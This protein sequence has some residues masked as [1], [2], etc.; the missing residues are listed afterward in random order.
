LSPVYQSTARAPCKLA[1]SETTVVAKIWVKTRALRFGRMIT[2][3][4]FAAS[5]GGGFLE[6]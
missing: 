2:I 3:H 6:R 4:F 5:H 1:M